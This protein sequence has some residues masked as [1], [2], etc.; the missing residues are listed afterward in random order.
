MGKRD[1]RVD[2]YIEKSPDFA[3][4]ILNSLR[5]VVHSACPDVEETMK[6][7]TPTFTYHG[8]LCG[9]AAFKQHCMFGFWKGSLFLPKSGGPGR[10]MR[11]YGRVTKRSDLPSDKVLAGYVKK[12]M[13]LNEEGVTAPRRS[14]AEP[15]TVVVPEILQTALKKNSKARKTFDSFSPSHKREYAEW[16]TQAKTEETRQRRVATAVEWL[17]KGKSRNWK[18]ERS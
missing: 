8:M 7:N 11:N 16:I 15:R 13:K 3:R 10:T 18:Y 5:D 17:A 4:P 9:M 12:A 1:P 2:A 6:W 14:R